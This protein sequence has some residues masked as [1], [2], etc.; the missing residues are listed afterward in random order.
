MKLEITSPKLS[1]PVSKS[2]LSLLTYHAKSALLDTN[3][4]ELTGLTFNFRDTSYSAELG[5]F[6]PVE[7]YLNRNK[8]AW[9]LGYITEFTY[10]GHTFPE[11]AKDVDF[12]IQNGVFSMLSAPDLPIDHGDVLEFYETWESNFLTY[13]KME[14]L[15]KIEVT[16]EG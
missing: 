11:L 4:D 9:E 15:D 3:I 8:A 7:I 12:D 10:V 16:K 6:R 5:G 2:L 1:L 14:C 13:C